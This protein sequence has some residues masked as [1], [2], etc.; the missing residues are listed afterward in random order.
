MQQQFETPEPISAYVEIPG[1]RLTVTAA[2]TGTTE[3][4]VEGPRAEE[5]HVD[6][7]GRQLSVLAPKGRFFSGH[8]RHAVSVTLPESS[9]LATKVGSADTR[10]VGSLREV[11]LKT[12]SGDIALDTVTGTL[13]VE[14]GSGDIAA[15]VLEGEVR[16]KSGSG[17]VDLGSIAGHAG[18]ST[19]SGD[20]TLGTVPAEVVVKTGSGDLKVQ[21]LSDKLVF[22]TA[23]GDLRVAHASQGSVVAKSASGDLVIAVPPGTPVWTDLNTVTGTVK[24]SLESTGAPAEGQAHLELRANT[25]SGDIRLVP[26]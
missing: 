20:V 11:I 21:R 2:D 13:S 26:A 15:H 4:T 1:G 19:G 10:V 18:I 8:E 5:F 9:N 12:G 16:I 17:D 25:V 23:S 6:F 22:A 3:V 7:T 24:S 14:S